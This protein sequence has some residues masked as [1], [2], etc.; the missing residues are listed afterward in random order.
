M[1]E[2]PFYWQEKYF[3]SINCVE[4]ICENQADPDN[5]GINNAQEFL[6]GTDPNNN[7]S[8]N[9]GTSDEQE[10]LHGRDPLKNEKN[11][12]KVEYED[13]KTKGTVNGELLKVGNVEME[14]VDG[15]K[16]IKIIGQAL[17][18]SFITIYVYS[19]PIIFS[20]KT[21]SDGSWS[22]ELDRDIEDGKHDVYVAITDNKGRIISKSNP[23][24]FIK[25]AQAVSVVSPNEAYLEKGNLFIVILISLGGLILAIITLGFIVRKRQEL[26]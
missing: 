21:N 6:L 13:P 11:G 1:G 25:T 23:L 17:P 3:G 14:D 18:N 26:R 7:D 15:Q 4:S 10:I 22:Y 24:S 2:T 16:K 12:D 9:D 19:D 8:D 20:I 5:D